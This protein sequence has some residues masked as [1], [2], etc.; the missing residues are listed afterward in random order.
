VPKAR[1]H[2]TPVPSPVGGSPLA[3]QSPIPLYYQ[4]AKVLQ[5]RIF[6]GLYPPGSQIATEEELAKT[7]AVSRI[8]VRK[9]IGVLHEQGLIERRR[10]RGTFV[11]QHVKASAVAQLHGF[12]EDLVLLGDI[13]RTLSCDIEQM[14]A[15]A[16]VAGRLQVPPGSSVTRISR[17]RSAGGSGADAWIVN[18]VPDDIGR[19]LDPDRLQTDSL[20]QLLNEIPGIRLADGFETFRACPADQE[21]ATRLSLPLGAPVLQLERLLQT[22]TGRIVD[23]GRFCQRGDRVSYSVRLTRIWR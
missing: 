8:T 10:P 17:V 1:T 6:T 20:V 15:D 21:T 4:V 19:A 3:Q 11:A 16:A 7:F 9:A 22:D 2:F 12:L 18:H 5:A 23:F 13:G 14:S